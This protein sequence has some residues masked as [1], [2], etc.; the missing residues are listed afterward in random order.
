LFVLPSEQEGM[1]AA[2][3]EAMAC[4]APPLGT[5]ISGVSDLIDD[6][7]DGRIVEPTPES[8]AD[9]FKYYFDSPELIRTHGERCRQKVLERYSANAVLAAYLNLFQL[10]RS[11]KDPCD[12][13]ILPEME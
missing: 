4:G 9:A 7:K 2:M 13:S 1:P 8:L 5:A 12:A 10:V 6:G 3:V 11:G